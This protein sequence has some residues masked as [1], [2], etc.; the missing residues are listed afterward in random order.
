M[1]EQS[2]TFPK[3]PRYQSLRHLWRGSF[4]KCS[5]ATCKFAAITPH[6]LST[7][8]LIPVDATLHVL[9]DVITGCAEHGSLSTQA[10]N[11]LV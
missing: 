2:T 4:N 11:L 3:R 5:H 7:Y 1:L 8:L 6:H 10:D 9:P